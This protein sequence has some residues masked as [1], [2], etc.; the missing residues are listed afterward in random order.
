MKLTPLLG[1]AMRCLPLTLSACSVAMALSGKPEPNFEAF[2]VGSTREQVEGQLG[3][4]L[5]SASLSGGQTRNT[6]RFEMGN[7]PNGH[8][9]LW[10]FYMDLATVGI[11]ELPGTIIEATMGEMEETHVVYSADGHVLAIEGYTPPKPTGAL[12]EAIEAQE[13][14]ARESPKAKP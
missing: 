14:A 10:N 6:Y 12:K 13:K 2:S 9:A 11:W 5:T 3:L 4:P 1:L 8:R 7:S